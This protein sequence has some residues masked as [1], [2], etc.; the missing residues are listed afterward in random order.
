MTK[1]LLLLTVLIMSCFYG[2]A[3][4]RFVGTIGPYPIEV[5]L[6]DFHSGKSQTADGYYVYKK[7]DEPIHLRGQ[8]DSTGLI[9]NEVN[10]SFEIL[11]TFNFPNF[12][13][14]DTLLNGNW[15]NSSR[16]YQVDLRREPDRYYD[17]AWQDS[18]E[19]HRQWGNSKHHYY[20]TVSD[21]KVPYYERQVYEVLVF[22]KGNDSLLQVISLDA[23]FRGM[24][25][26]L[27]EDINFDGV[28]DLY[29]ILY[30]GMRSNVVAAYWVFEDGQYRKL[31]YEGLTLDVDHERREISSTYF[32]GV[33]GS[34]HIQYKWKDGELV[35]ASESHYKPDF[36]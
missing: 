16:R 32:D 20:K 33:N 25:N 12:K 19:L 3:Q 15:T 22:N 17:E 30:S 26:V 7:Y 13:R 28:Q 9:L 34:T 14:S 11:A 18:L 10:D 5:F 1:Q 24:Y 4:Q 8:L 29:V 6:G 31:E 27:T 36:D 35:K 23:H 21:P 2:H